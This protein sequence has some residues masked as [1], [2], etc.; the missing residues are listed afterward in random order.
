[1]DPEDIDLDT[2]VERYLPHRIPEISWE[3]RL[4]AYW[5]AAVIG[6]TAGGIFLAGASIPSG[7]PSAA[8]LVGLL[9]AILGGGELFLQFGLRKRRTELRADAA[10]GELMQ[11]IASRFRAEIEEYRTRTLGPD[12]EWA[13]ARTPLSEAQDEANRS[14][15]YW[16]ERAAEH[17]D[18]EAALAQ[19]R[20]ATSLEEKFARA[21]AEIDE[22]AVALRTF[23]NRCEARLARL[24]TANRDREERE[25]LARLSK[26]AKLEVEN[27]QESLARI[28]AEFVADALRVGNALAGLQRLRL[29]NQAGHLD[30]D[31]LE[32]VAERIAE[33]S[34]SGRQE[35]DALERQLNGEG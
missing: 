7:W 12:S 15:A 10:S 24:D 8:I 17:E 13:R 25:R 34:V 9:T 19:L 3:D 26:R 21:V 22:R 18:P 33:V 20:L 16:T 11:D 5:G 32:A 23:F 2:L 27:A 30:L 4:A 31:E 1:M 35:L 14:A 6:L 29:L 28:G